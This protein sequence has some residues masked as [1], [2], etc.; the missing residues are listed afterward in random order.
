MQR[1]GF[2]EQSCV[3]MR[4]NVN[5]DFSKV[6]PI[7]KLAPEEKAEMIDNTSRY[8]RNTTLF[9]PAFYRKV[10]SRECIFSHGKN[11]SLCSR[12]LLWF[13]ELELKGES[14]FLPSGLTKERNLQYSTVL[15]FFSI[16][17]C[18]LFRWVNFRRGYYY[19]YLRQSCRFHMKKVVETLPYATP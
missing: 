8:M 6:P 5:N 16:Q 1:D 7:K 13:Q 15:F 17:N 2:F 14:A 19:Y 3:L 18:R 12:W 9:P 11:C 4:Q 10:K